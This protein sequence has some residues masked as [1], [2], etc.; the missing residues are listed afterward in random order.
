MRPLDEWK[1]PHRVLTTTMS[2]LGMVQQ[3][4]SN[5]GGFWNAIMT[6]EHS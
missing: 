2:A 4:T 3:G 1:K 5:A 6:P